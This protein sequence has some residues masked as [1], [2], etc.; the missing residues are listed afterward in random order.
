MSQLEPGQSLLHFKI[1]QKLGQ[2]GMGEVYRALDTKLGRRVAIKI[3]P[4]STTS[5]PDAAQRF[6]E[7]ARLASALNHPNVVTIYSVDRAEGYEFIVMELVEGETLLAR[8]HR[9]PLDYPD[10]LDLGVQI[11]E[12]LA[13]AH[14]VGLVH[15]DIKSANILITKEG[16]AKVLDFGLAKRVVAAVEDADVGATVLDLTRSGVVMGTPAYMS[17]EQTRGDPVDARSDLFSL[18]IVLYEGA[19]GRLPFAGPSALAIMHEIAT[20]DPVPASRAAPAYP[21]EFDL[22]LGRAMAKDPDERYATAR[23]LADALR[24]LREGAM[25]TTAAVALPRGGLQGPNNLP[26]QLTSFIGRKRERGEVKRLFSS[27]RLV[28]VM[29]AGGCGKT[30]LAIHV[31][32]D[33]LGELPAGAWFVDLAPVADAEVVPQAV[34]GALGVREEPGRPL[35]ATLA[36]AIGAQAML[37]VLDNCEHLAAGCARLAEGLLRA[38]PALRVLATSR[39]GLGV[40]GEI[41]WRIPTL[42][43]PDIRASLPTNKD[44]AARYESVRLFVERAV[45][46][47]PAFSLTDANAP[48][49]S[50][51]CHRL[52]GIPLAIELAAVRVKVLSVE[53]ILARLTD[54]F[55]LLTGGS[56]TALPRQ[57]TLRAAVDWSY[58]MLA[59]SERTLLN[60]LGVFAGGCTLEAAEEICLWNGLASEDS[61]DLLSRLV[62]KSLVVP[63]EGA[64]GSMRYG[65]LETIRAYAQERAGAEGESE[66]LLDRHAATYLALA[67]AAEPQLRGPEQ[68]AWLNRLE[69]EHDNLRQALQT[70]TARGNADAALRLA[71]SLWRFWWVRGIWTEGRG[72]LESV[73]ALEGAT[74]RTAAR[75]S[76]LRAAAV[77]ARGQGDYDS[78]RALLTESLAIARE[79]GNRAGIAA[80]LFELGNIANDH[81]RLDE[82]RDL[83]RQ[84]LEI[85]RELGD[86][87]GVSVAL[88]NLAVVAEAQKDFA[89]ARPLYEEALAAHRELGNQA[90]VA[91]TLN[92]LGELLLG[93]GDAVGALDCQARALAIQREL[94]DKRGMAFSLRELGRIE[95]ARG[96]SKGFVHLAECIQI[97]ESLGD[98]L[99]MAVAMEV[100]AAVSART[101]QPERAMKLMGVATAIREAIDS[102]ISIV[103]AELLEADLRGAREALGESRVGDALAAGKGLSTEQAVALALE[104]GSAAVAHRRGSG[105][106]P[107]TRVLP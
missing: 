89:N 47:V 75:G 49:V 97:L 91:A 37:L 99:G 4:P 35:E 31:A 8:L 63:E 59:P 95:A 52:D 93:Q 84:S 27:A 25:M 54:R 22:V 34:A 43:V 90:M 38:C 81:E 28:T 60:R 68:V 102:P 17:P 83:Y 98:R 77:L 10:L 105:G 9:Q 48:I 62:D 65:L 16:R 33:F 5:N 85:R 41:L 15:R 30:R 29:G 80:S 74:Q 2:G 39:E 57:Q 42:S 50:Q 67:E 73:L 46:S 56:R 96:D 72:R 87:W 58:E 21:P 7:E 100:C 32:G 26:M 70:L 40:P 82:A 14:A 20:A 103:D 101:E 64:D 55:Q 11:S 23:E 12:A 76:A 66:A 61:L 86:R 45:A 94:G 107:E 88:H 24:G 13:A 92:G 69:E 106:G 19:T 53:K 78:A 104:A 3:L 1:E 79:R 51:I 44:V 18:A 71:A 6:R 36:E